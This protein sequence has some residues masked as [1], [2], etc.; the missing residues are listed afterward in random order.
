MSSEVHTRGTSILV[1]HFEVRECA[2]EPYAREQG[3]HALTWEAKRTD[4]SSFTSTA[5]GA[6]IV[7]PWIFFKKCLKEAGASAFGGFSD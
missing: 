3:L 2:R 4:D 7:M 5:L 1:G 6:S